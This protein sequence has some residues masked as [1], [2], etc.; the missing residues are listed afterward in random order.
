MKRRHIGIALAAIV[1]FAG[2][3]FGR[4]AWRAHHNLVTLHARNMPLADVVRSLE[5]QTWEK[6]RYDN[7]LGAKITLDVKNVP[8]ERVLDM[9]ADK[10]G[11]RWQ[12]TYAVGA[13]G[14]AMAKLESV[15]RGAE[16]LDAAGWTNL[17][18]Q[19]APMDLPDFSNAGPE[20][21]Q[22]GPRRFVHRTF[23]NGAPGGNGSGPGRNAKMVS[24]LPDGTIDQ[25]S[26]D[27]LVLETSL[28]AQL[29]AASPEEATPET[30]AH[31]AS[32]V[33][34][35]SRLYYALEQAPFEMGRP[36][37]LVSAGPRDNGSNLAGSG[38]IF[39]AMAQER[40]QRRLR[41][42]SRSPEEQLERAR[43]NGTNKMRLETEETAR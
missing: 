14:G 27:R 33:H 39:A 13:S 34:G 23:S 26:S 1:A 20:S 4:L 18:P 7:R 16:K 29:G 35:Q 2:L 19:F 40:Q 31:V 8:L 10:A 15:L 38:D 36:G 43:R 6:I 22:G 12:K 17:A 32:A 21:G 42:L 11:A 28:L 9:V 5:W 25:W 24:I 41:E 30:A 3:W 37:R